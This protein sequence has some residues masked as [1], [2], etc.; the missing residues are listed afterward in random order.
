MAAGSS[1]LEAAQQFRMFLLSDRS[2][3]S[4]YASLVRLERCA[5]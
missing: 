2:V 1:A 4:L 3:F 5:A